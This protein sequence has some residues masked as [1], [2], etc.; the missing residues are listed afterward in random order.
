MSKLRWLIG[1]VMAA[2]MAA[3]SSVPSAQRQHQRQ[4]AYVAA[5]GSAVPHF[6]F[7]TLYSWEPLSDKQVVIYTRANEAWLLDLGGGC[8][9]LQYTPGIAVTS[10]FSQVSIN[11]DKILTGR[12]YFPCTITQIR[13][14]D[15]ARLKIEQQAQRTINSQ[16]RN[17]TS[18][19]GT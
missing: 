14:V 3:C 15:V 19:A 7:V 13:P 17:Q 4:E 18:P 10:M 5:A 2:C 9:Q 11:F 12:D 8:P 6:R 16:P 1:L